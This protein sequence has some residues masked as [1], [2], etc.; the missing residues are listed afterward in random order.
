MEQP[1]GAFHFAVLLH[2]YFPIIFNKII[3]EEKIH[4]KSAPSYK[5]KYQ[6]RVG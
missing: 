5:A 1:I 6:V 3:M 2:L 4:F